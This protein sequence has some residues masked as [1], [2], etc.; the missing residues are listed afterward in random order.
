MRNGL[1]LVLCAGVLAGPLASLATAQWQDAQMYKYSGLTRD[2][3][4]VYGYSQTGLSYPWF[5]CQYGYYDDCW[6]E[7][8]SDAQANLYRDSVWQHGD[9]STQDNGPAE[10]WCYATAAVGYWQLIHTH[11]VDV[12]WIDYWSPEYYW[13]QQ[14]RLESSGSR[15]LTLNPE[16]SISGGQIAYDGDGAYF[17]VAVGLGTPTSY[18][19]SFGYPSGAGNSPNVQ[20]SPQNNDYT[21][22]DAHWFAYPNGECTASGSAIYDITSTVGFQSG[23]LSDTTMLDVVVPWQPGGEYYAPTLTLYLY[24]YQSGGLWRVDSS[25]F[26]TRSSPFAIVNV[27]SYSQFH[28]KTAAHEQV[29]V[30]QYG[31]GRMRGDLYSPTDARNA[32]MNLTHSTE[33]GLIALAVATVASYVQSQESTDASRTAQAEAEAYGI[34]DN[35]APWY[36][37]QNCG[38]Y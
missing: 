20:F 34:S 14:D 7:Y 10:A 17:D 2:G 37:Y 8:T 33:Q 25:T 1:R 11:E 12:S 31:S 19:W 26:L 6:E 38:R 5:A 18:S 9:A 28:S 24:R 29:H 16:I 4:D 23:P 35:I 21:Y 32:I 13:W 36:V 22:T 30:D 15:S 3:S 27:P